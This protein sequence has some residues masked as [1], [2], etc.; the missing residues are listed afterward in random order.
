MNESKSYPETNHQG[1][2]SKTIFGFWL[3]ILTDFM[4]FATIFA[5][6]AVLKGNT[7]GGPT[8]QDLFDFEYTT[9]QT[10]IFLFST[11]TIGIGNVYAHQKK[12][13]GTILFY[14][15][16]FILGLTFL[17]LELHELSRFT[18]AGSG[19]SQNAFASSF[20]S[21]IG[22]F[23]LHLILGLLWVIILII[24]VLKKR[25]S[26][27]S[28]LRLTCLKMFWQFLNVIWVFIYTIVYLLGII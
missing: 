18:L 7:F 24:P 17:L 9:I 4:L 3:Y 5:T 22:I 14:L 23:L 6:Y 20:F 11:F 8:Q 25:V 26:D 1:T 19:L 28:I 12:W 27:T 15:V 2:Y 10:F 21:L 16:S 13:K